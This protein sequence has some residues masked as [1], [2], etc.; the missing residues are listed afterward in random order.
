M[1]EMIDK[2]RE[3]FN[4]DNGI[5]DSATESTRPP[6]EE[7]IDRALFV[8]NEIEL[9][10]TYGRS[11]EAAREAKEAIAELTALKTKHEEQTKIME[12]LS[13]KVCEIDNDE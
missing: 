2:M 10:A 8:L 3:I 5:D 9:Y 13:G 12:V 1:S 6:L 4:K 7:A 11:G